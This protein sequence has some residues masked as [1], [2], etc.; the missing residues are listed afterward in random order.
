MEKRKDKR[1][2]VKLYVKLN[3]GS[4]ISWGALGDVSE[5]GLFIRSNRGFTTDAVID[6]EIFMPDN[7]VS[8]LKGVVRRIVKLPESNRKFGI[9]VEL[10]GKDNAYRRL[11]KILEGRTNAV[12]QTLP[13][14]SSKEVLR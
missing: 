14:V 4:F 1:F 9:G 5:N 12:E 8:H 2:D 7:T 6:I 10:V 13:T 3:S 11:L